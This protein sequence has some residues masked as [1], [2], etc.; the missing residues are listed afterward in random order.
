MSSSVLVAFATR[1]GSTR[2][3]A[4]RIA[5]VLRGGGPDVEGEAVLT[6]LDRAGIAASTGSACTAGSTE[7]SHVLRAMGVPFTFA[8]GSIRFSLSIYNTDSEIDFV[9]AQLP[10]IINRLRE[11]SPFGKGKAD[12]AHSRSC[13]E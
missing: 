6:H 4:E 3:V 1:Y 12:I 8:H 5:Q 2:E 13:Q 10:A 11:I 9:L 7:P